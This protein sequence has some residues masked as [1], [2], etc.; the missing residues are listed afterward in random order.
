MPFFAIFEL[1]AVHSSEN[2]ELTSH[3]LRTD[4][5]VMEVASGITSPQVTIGKGRAGAEAAAANLEP[6]TIGA[7]PMHALPAFIHRERPN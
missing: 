7:T 5:F 3:Q 1:F 2:F 6:L 4:L